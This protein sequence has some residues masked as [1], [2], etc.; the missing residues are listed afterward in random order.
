MMTTKA[1]LASVPFALLL[2]LAP[3]K[4]RADD[5]EAI[6]QVLASYRTAVERLN[7]TGTERLF[8]V[9]ALVFEGG[10]PEGTYGRYLSH[11]L[12]PEL[13]ALRG[14]QFSDYKVEVRIDGAYGLAWESYSYTI[15]PKQG[16]AYQRTG[17][18]TSVLKRSSDSTW[19]IVQRHN[20][21]R[22]PKAG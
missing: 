11:H 3:A 9:D 5:A 20:S 22:R 13:T 1:S 10:V 2:L 17:V 15:T 12:G 14:F 19:L 6:K 21:T 7:A 8:S 18:A 16:E 4:A